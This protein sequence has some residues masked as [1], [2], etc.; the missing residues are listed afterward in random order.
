MEIKENK[1]DN[2]EEEE[3]DGKRKSFHK[4]MI[5]NKGRKN[6]R[7]KVLD[8]SSDNIFKTI[9]KDHKKTYF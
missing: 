8:V 9:R 6:I 4:E 3:K 7:K 5:V 2:E 1:F